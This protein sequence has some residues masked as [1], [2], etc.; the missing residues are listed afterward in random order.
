MGV[1][2]EAR[3]DAAPVPTHVAR[4]RGRRHRDARATRRD[5]QRG[6]GPETAAGDRRVARPAVSVRRE[7]LHGPA[8]RALAR[9]TTGREPPSQIAMRQPVPA[10]QARVEMGALEQDDRSRGDTTA[11]DVEAPRRDR[12]AIPELHR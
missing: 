1:A 12:D 11:M 3:V 7:V 2:V 8:L 6:A 10:P 4:V 9:A 5:D